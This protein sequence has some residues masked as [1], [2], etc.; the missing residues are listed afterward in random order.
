MSYN[1]LEDKLN[2]GKTLIEASAG[3]GKTFSVAM[4]AL[5]L[6]IEKDFK[7]KEILL[8]TFTNLATAELKKRIREFLIVAKEINS[9]GKS[10]H[11]NQKLITDLLNKAKEEVSPQDITLRINRAC[12]QLDDLQVFTIHGFLNL[13]MQEFALE[14]N[15]RFTS[16]LITDEKDIVEDCIK[17]FWRKHISSKSEKELNPLVNP[18]KPCEINSSIRPLQ[19]K[20]FRN[21]V[22]DLSKGKM[23]L[24]D[25]YSKE[26]I[27]WEN[28]E[29]IIE[30]KN[31]KFINEAII[32]KDDI[33][34]LKQEYGAKLQ[35]KKNELWKKLQA[36]E[37]D[38]LNSIDPSNLSELDNRA[39][40]YC[41]NKFNE[42][43]GLFDN[44]DNGKNVTK[45]YALTQQFQTEIQ[46]KIKDKLAEITQTITPE[47]S[48]LTIQST[49]GVNYIINSLAYQCFLDIKTTLK[50]LKDE[51]NVRSNDDL[52]NEFHKLATSNNADYI[53]HEL[54]NRYKA[55]FID[56]FQDTD[57]K[58][59]QIFS[60]LFNSTIVQFFVG[61]PKQSIYQ[62]RGADLDNYLNFKKELQNDNIKQLDKNFR[63]TSAYVNLCNNY[64]NEEN[65]FLKQ[66]V[67]YQRVSA[68]RENECG[69]LKLVPQEDQALEKLVLYLLKDK[70]ITVDNKE[71]AILPKDIAI[72][73]TKNKHCVT[74]KKKLSKIN[75]PAVLFYDKNIFDSDEA[76]SMETFCKL[77]T[78]QKTTIDFR[79][80][81]V[82]SWF[83][84]SAEEI[85]KLNEEKVVEKM[86]EVYLD[87]SKNGFYSAFQTFRK[88][89]Q[90]QK[91]MQKADFPERTL[92]NTEQLLEICHQWMITEKLSVFSIAKKISDL[93]SNE[94]A[95]DE[96]YQERIESDE[97]AVQ[98]MTMHKA[99]G[100]EFKVVITEDLESLNE[101]KK[102]DYNNRFYDVKLNNQNYFITT[103]FNATDWKEFLD[104]A[105]QIKKEENK[106]LEYVTLTRA[107]YLFYGIVN[108]SFKKYNSFKISSEELSSINTFTKG[109]DKNNKPIPNENLITPTSSNI[110]TKNIYA[111]SVSSF[112]DI[113]TSPKHFY[114][115]EE[116]NITYNYYDEFI[117]K[118]VFKGALAG[119]LIHE[120]LEH[121]D[122]DLAKTDFNQAV[123]ETVERAEKRYPDFLIHEEN[124]SS[125]EI[126]VKHV[127]N[128]KIPGFSNFT[129]SQL[130]NNQRVC[131]LDFHMD[132][133]NTPLTQ[134]EIANIF[135]N[136]KALLKYN[137]PSNEDKEGYL[138]GFIDFIFEYNGKY[139]ILDWKSNHIGYQKE[140]YNQQLMEEA[141]Q[142]SNYHLQHY[143]YKKAFVHYLATVKDITVDKAEEEFGGVIYCFVRGCRENEEYGM[144]VYN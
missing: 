51:Q 46:L 55:F 6:I 99:K 125:F 75:V 114:T 138:K 72:L 127:L 43:F 23:L 2:P 12:Y 7:V 5:R 70:K 22:S 110:N 126:L 106:R 86:N 15:Q 38:F 32:I 128:A 40:N 50:K 60:N 130:C 52:I 117:F 133:T 26:N 131:E 31:Q 100:L 94:Y 41:I 80:L 33:Q 85:K 29:E 66:G 84:F 47:K 67:D 81:L 71:I 44:S 144:Y 124:K 120:L 140:N 143:I 45:Y 111:Y 3:T 78:E 116:Q 19:F 35:V 68:E 141:M 105:N 98:I 122:F 30:D 109:M 64:F 139:Y 103:Y 135:P 104:I 96:I 88:L 129:L 77:L 62:F 27:N 39:T 1:Y 112:S 58:Q 13:M 14:T 37:S 136:G 107:E 90:I 92:T 42:S 57:P 61:D 65:F 11:K 10:S 76:K 16:E 134:N 113:T 119:N 48:K 24:P 9:N 83:N 8:V 79:N 137:F 28:I 74:V 69:E 97:D 118:K 95:E 21:I 87:F 123:K 102:I 121:F 82:S 132:L 18:Q 59:A 36:T 73:C 89:F 20:Y 34:K 108:E 4:L 91:R 54:N 56:E 49:N 25:H 115:D 17:Q 63:S 101:I 93:R 142:A 53:K